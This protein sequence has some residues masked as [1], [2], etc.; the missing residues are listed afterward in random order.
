MNTS[1]RSDFPTR[2]E[3]IQGRLLFGAIFPLLF[4]AEGLSRAY[5]HIAA[6]EA[7]QDNVQRSLFAEARANTS[8]ATSYLLMARAMLH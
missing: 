4:A 5:A 3:G 2:K 8:I 7:G 6:G 1:I